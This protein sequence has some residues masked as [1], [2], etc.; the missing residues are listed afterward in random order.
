MT[1]PGSRVASITTSYSPS[2]SASSTSWRRQNPQLRLWY[3][4]L[5]GT[6]SGRAGSLNRC[7][8]KASRERRS[9]TGSLY[10]SR[11]RLSS[12]KS[13]IRRPSGAASHASR[14]FHSGGSVQS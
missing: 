6:T 4:V 10:P 5:K 8:R 2:G 9:R 12:A 7:G 11:C 1:L 14:T 3:E 13:A